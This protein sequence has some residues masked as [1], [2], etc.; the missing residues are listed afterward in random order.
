QRHG[1]AGQSLRGEPLRLLFVGDSLCNGVGSRIAAPLQV[2][3]AEKLADLRGRPVVWR[4]VSAT[5]ADARE[6]RA[7]LLHCEAQDKVFDIA[8]VIC[9]VNDGKKIL[10]G[11]WPSV[12]RQ[13]LA[14]LCAALRRQAPNGLITVPCISGYVNAPLLQL[15]PL[16]HFAHVFFDAFEAQKRSLAETGAIHCCT[17]PLESSLPGPDAGLWS[18]DGVHPSAEGYREVG[19][20]IGTT[21]G[22]GAMA[23]LAVE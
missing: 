1:R 11:R 8:V 2:A 15:W 6:L 17:P 14:E 3:C 4:T 13:D 16:R 21:L 9:G 7:L 5:G 20:W 22:I 19:E 12:F 18:V 10:Q 23:T